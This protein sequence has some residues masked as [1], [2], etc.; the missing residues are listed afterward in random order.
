MEINAAEI[1]KQKRIKRN[2]DNLRDLK[3]LNIRILGVP[4]EKDEKKG[5][6]KIFEE[7]IVE[8]FPQMGKEIVTQV[9]ETQGVQNRITQ[10]E[11]PHDTY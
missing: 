5:Y 7:I 1:K 4:E 11:I 3:C 2:E 8:N 10:G 9:Q 6:E